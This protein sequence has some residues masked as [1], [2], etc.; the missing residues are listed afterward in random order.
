MTAYRRFDESPPAGA[1]PQQDLPARRLM[2]K[3]PHSGSGEAQVAAQPSVETPSYLELALASRRAAGLPDEIEDCDTWRAF[4]RAISHGGLSHETLRTSGA[5][6]RFG[7]HAVGRPSE[8]AAAA[9]A[10]DEVPRATDPRS[11]LPS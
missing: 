4:G 3:R 6:T 9:A 11:R 2:L 5:E 8:A 7:V 10:E 1:T